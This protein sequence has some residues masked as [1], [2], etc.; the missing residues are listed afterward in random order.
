VDYFD[1]L[2]NKI[3]T[4]D[5]IDFSEENFCSLESFFRFELKYHRNLLEIFVILHNHPMNL[6]KTFSLISMFSLLK[7]EKLINFV[8]LFYK[9]FATNDR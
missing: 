5:L 3:K 2:G 9:L 4:E 8:F 6:L 1:F 7:D